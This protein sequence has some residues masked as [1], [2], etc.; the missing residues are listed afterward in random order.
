[1]TSRQLVRE[2]AVWAKD[3]ETTNDGTDFAMRYD[4]ADARE[5]FFEF[6]DAARAIHA[7]PRKRIGK[8]K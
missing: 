1:M 2:L 8:G 5:I 7:K 3:G 6:I 4:P